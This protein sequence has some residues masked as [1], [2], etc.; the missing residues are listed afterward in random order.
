MEISFLEEIHDMPETATCSTPSKWSG[1]DQGGDKMHRPL[2]E[3]ALAKHLVARVLV[4][5]KSTKRRSNRVCAFVEHPRPKP[6]QLRP[7][8]CTQPR[9]GFR[10]FPCRAAWSLSCVVQ[11]SKHYTL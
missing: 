8:K 11:Q 10:Q 1:W 4:P 6:E 9:A 3:S 2:G 5:G 7:G